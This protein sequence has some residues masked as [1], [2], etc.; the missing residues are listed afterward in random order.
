MPSRILF[1]SSFSGRS[2]IRSLLVLPTRELALQVEAELRKLCGSKP[3]R[4]TVL[5]SGVSL[6]PNAP[7]HAGLFPYLPL[8]PPILIS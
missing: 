6:D 4:I 2:G 3:F 5:T 1:R 7:L 8:Y